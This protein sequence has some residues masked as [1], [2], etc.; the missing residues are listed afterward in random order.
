M[1]QSQSIV[2]S[3]ESGAGK[4]ESAKIL[5]R[6]ITWRSGAA[7][8]QVSSGAISTVNDRIVQSNPILEALGNAKTQRNHN[9]SRFGKYISIKFDAHSVPGELKL[10]GA[11]I[12]TYLLEKSRIVYQLQGERCDHTLNNPIPNPHPNP[13]HPNPN[14]DSKP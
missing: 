2:V 1:R 8:P 6:Y 10:L 3:G 11:S 14:P 4:T 7:A 12:E 9:S 5:M 13:S